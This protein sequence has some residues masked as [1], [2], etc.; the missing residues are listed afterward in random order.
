MEYN[1]VT[2]ALLGCNTDAS[3]LGSVSQAKL[4]LCYILIYMVKPSAPLA[5]SVSLIMNDRQDMETH[6]SVANDSGTPKRTAMHFLNKMVNNVSGLQ[7]FSAQTA[8]ACLLGMP[9]E[10]CTHEFHLL[11]I[12]GALKYIDELSA[13]IKKV[14]LNFPKLF[15]SQINFF[16]TIKLIYYKFRNKESSKKRINRD[17]RIWKHGTERSR[18]RKL[19]QRRYIDRA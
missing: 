10:T 7:E 4:A 15:S 2:S 11:F 8:A 9:A 3:F 13:D 12:D 19:L 5:K 16:I 17:R 1:K 6:P 18:K 14:H